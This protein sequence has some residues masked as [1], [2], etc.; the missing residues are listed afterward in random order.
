MNENDIS[1][2]IVDSAIEV[3]R[4]LGGPGLLESVYEYALYWE[5]LQ[6][7]LVV[8]RQ[9]ELPVVYKGYMLPIPLRLEMVVQN[10]VIVE[11]KA[12][13]DNHPVF[14]SQLLTYLRISG[15]R[16]GLLVNFGFSVISRGISRV[17]N[18]LREE[19]MDRYPNAKTLKR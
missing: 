11:C 5:L 17:V 12:T 8:E 3:H 1:K 15:L 4:T 14:K 7:E 6:K 18:G 19:E 2:L 13:L 16:L 10:L 9:R